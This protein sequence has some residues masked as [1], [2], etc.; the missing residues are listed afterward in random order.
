MNIY[1][2]NVIKEN[3]CVFCKIKK[4]FDIYIHIIYTNIPENYNAIVKKLENIVFWWL[5]FWIFT[6]NHYIFKQNIIKRT[7]KENILKSRGVK[8]WVELKKFK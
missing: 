3:I 1:Y 4:V 6:T 5:E 7:K 2:R 8:F